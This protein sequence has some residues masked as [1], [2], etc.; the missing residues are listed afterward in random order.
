MNNLKTK[1]I[2]L[3]TLILLIT[4]YIF[5]DDLDNLFDD[6]TIMED[7]EDSLFD[8]NSENLFFGDAFI[9]EEDNQSSDLESGSLF[10]DLLGSNSQAM[11]ITG[12]YSF[13]FETGINYD[14][15]NKD[16]PTSF[17]E[18]P[19]SADLILSARPTTETR[20]LMKSNI[21]YPF[22]TDTVFT[23]KELFADF[24]IKD[25]F[26][27]VGKQTLNWGVGYF[28]S[29]ANLLNSQIDIF[30]PEDD[31]EG[32]LAI[33]INRPID[34]DNLY[35]YVIV[36]NKSEPVTEDLI[37]AIKAEKLLNNSEIAIGGL[38]S[39]SNE[40]NPSIMATI[41]TSLPYSINIFAEAVETY[42]NDEFMF[43]ST[44]GFSSFKDFETI[45][46][47]SMNILAQYYYNQGGK[48]SSPGVGTIDARHQLGGTIS[49]SLPNNFSLSL[50][51]LNNLSD[52]SGAL[53]PSVGYSVSDELSIIAS[54]SYY[55][56]DI[57]DSFT[58]LNNSYLKS[59]I[60]FSVG[61]DF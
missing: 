20:F 25:N 59:S 45:N 50:V 52:F 43:S 18:V 55:Y 49:L 2:I 29:P 7:S 9:I 54:M 34:N 21:A 24:I 35:A 22:D 33:K 38:Y 61:G 28:Y 19:L 13:D 26:F 30:N 40:T 8:D 5:S 3:L 23:I 10:E 60:K 36:P 47:T 16:A 15:V 56:G 6:P 37:Y 17:L 12:S 44:I 39:V 14:L 27:R 51:S 53:T 41:S 42:Q 32:P 31:L 11:E 1:V 48:F 4:P 58:L 57:G 46:D